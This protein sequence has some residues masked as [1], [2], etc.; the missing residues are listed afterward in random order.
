MTGYLMVVLSMFNIAPVVFALFTTQYWKHFTVTSSKGD[1]IELETPKGIYLLF[2]LKALFSVLMYKVGRDAIK[3]FKPVVADIKK[4]QLEGV[5]SVENR[6]K[7]SKMFMRRTGCRAVKGLILL[8]I[9]FFA[10]KCFA[11]H[12]ASHV[13]EEVY[14]NH[15]ETEKSHTHMKGEHHWSFFGKKE[16]TKAPH[17]HA[18]PTGNEEDPERQMPALESAPLESKHDHKNKHHESRGIQ[19]NMSNTFS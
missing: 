6:S 1:Q 2:V 5:V 19:V 12:A 10:T 14:A 16:E 7:S 13:I 8:V 11:N 17:H 15:F 3:T 18:L 9:S 4:E